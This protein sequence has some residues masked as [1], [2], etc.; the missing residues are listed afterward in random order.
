MARY[1]PAALSDRTGARAGR[2]ASRR[3]PRTLRATAWVDGVTEHGGRLTV[4]VTDEAAASAGL[5]P[6]VV[7]AGLRL[8]AFERVRP[9]LEDVFLRLVGREPDAH[10][11]EP[12][13]DRRLRSCFARSC[14]SRGGPCGC[15]SSAGL[16]L[17]VGLTSPL[18]ARF[19]PEIIKAAAGDQL[20]S[21]PLPTPVAADAVA[22]TLEEPRPI[23]GICRDRPGDGR[24]L[25]RNGIAARPRSCCPSR[26]RA[27]AFIGAKVVG[28]G[29]ILGLCTA[30]AVAVAWIYTAILF[31]PPSVAGWVA[32]AAIA[33][34]GL[35][36]W[37]ALTFLGSTV[38]GSTAA[39]AG[40][41]FG[42]LL[43]LS[44][45]S[46]IPNVGR[47]L[48]GGLAAPAIALAVGRAG[49]CRGRARPGG[50]DGRC[51]SRRLSGSRS[52]RSVAR[53]S[54]PE[55]GHAARPPGRG[56]RDL[57]SPGSA[58]PQ[59][60]PRARNPAISSAPYP[61]SPRIA[62]VS[63]PRVGGG[64]LIEAGVAGQLE[65]DPDLADQPHAGCSCSTVIPSATA[66]G[67]ANAA[68]MSLIG[69]HG[70]SAASRA[71][72]QSAVGR[73][74]KR[75]AR[76]GRS[77]A[78]CS[79]RSPLVANRRSSARLGQPERGAQPR[80]LA[81]RADGD[82]DRAVGRRERLVRDDVRVGVAEPARARR[83]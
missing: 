51:S 82:R 5:L 54:E 45:G 33:W 39:A 49:R 23:R 78:R 27:G 15:R 1:R 32:L 25:P 79:T 21:I 47:F 8:A 34:L 35:C 37:A 18:L 4:S 7:A 16:F 28:I 12:P 64:V 31:E 40:I 61:S 63:W 9:S 14:S 81:L 55:T 62:S 2:G 38:T 74:A 60:T 72:S 19:L 52:G 24:P 26:S 17:L 20:P 42:A 3:S 70:I 58:R 57:P 83:P 43:L 10:E 48:P 76:I 41:G 77:S 36:A 68:T 50:L 80:P 59:T 65:R 13:H 44:I 30:L 69:P 67:E 53:S 6:L 22:Q 73:A 66:S 46:A 75:S 29:A 11:G 71:V 56:P